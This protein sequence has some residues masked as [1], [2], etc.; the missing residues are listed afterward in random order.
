MERY[1]RRK[2]LVPILLDLLILC[3]A[4]VNGWCFYED[5][6]YWMNSAPYPFYAFLWVQTFLI[7]MVI[8]IPLLRFSNRCIECSLA[9]TIISLFLNTILGT[10]WLVKIIKEHEDFTL[11][12]F[13]YIEALIVLGI[14]LL[15]AMFFVISLIVAIILI[16]MEQRRLRRWQRFE[17]DPGVEMEQIEDIVENYMN[18]LIEVKFNKASD[19][20]KHFDCA[21]CLKEF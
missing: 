14:P 17:E 3:L 18:M 11:N 20:N 7:M 1:R 8:R 6:D 19:E 12:T 10:S 16:T 15:I 13:Y 4:G 2:V 5:Y 21:I 9:L